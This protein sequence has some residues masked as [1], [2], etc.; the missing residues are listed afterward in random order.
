MPSSLN[1]TD[2]FGLSH[3]TLQLIPKSSSNIFIWSLLSTGG[4]CNPKRTGESLL[5]AVTLHQVKGSRFVCHQWKE[6]HL[7]ASFKWCFCLFLLPIHLW[8]YCLFF[9]FSLPFYSFQDCPFELC[10]TFLHGHFRDCHC[11][12]KAGRA[13]KESIWWELCFSEVYSYLCWNSSL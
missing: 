13:E 10:S 9:S 1:A 6:C 4:V 12:V 8:N 5:L 7:K 2:G 11:Q 3:H